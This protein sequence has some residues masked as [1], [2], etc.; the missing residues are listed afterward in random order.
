M[1][2]EEKNIEDVLEEKG[3]NEVDKVLDGELKKIDD[4]RGNV[5][6]SFVT[7]IKQ[8]S[9]SQVVEEPTIA[10]VTLYPNQISEK[11]MKEHYASVK[12]FNRELEKLP[13]NDSGASEWDV[14]RRGLIDKLLGKFASR[15]L[16]VWGIASAALFYKILPPDT[17]AT[18]SIAYIGSQAF[19][20]F[21]AQIKGQKK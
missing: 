4:V 11:E 19:V 20:D 1:S 2:K 5:D 21:V 3:L 15:K 16:L 14:D 9:E 17:W 13:V 6:E 10:D 7:T 12:E 8:A 18:I